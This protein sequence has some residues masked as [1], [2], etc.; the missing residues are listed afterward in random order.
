LP[1]KARYPVYNALCKS[2]SESVKYPVICKERYINIIYI[3]YIGT[4]MT[5][6]HTSFYVP[7]S[8]VH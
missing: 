1:F 8:V 4:F 2:S 6:H 7:E 5:C 3:R